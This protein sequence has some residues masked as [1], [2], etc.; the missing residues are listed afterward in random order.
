[1]F[2]I[3]ITNNKTKHKECVSLFSSKKDAKCEMQFLASEIISELSENESNIYSLI[4]DS[5]LKIFTKHKNIGWLSNQI[6][7]ICLYTL[8]II[9]FKKSNEKVTNNN[10][11]T[12]TH[13]NLCESNQ[14]TQTENNISYHSNQTPSPSLVFLDELRAKLG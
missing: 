3:L 14:S 12:Q 7:D 13:S 9:Q 1:M 8:D 5:T 2:T 10:I 6:V 4:N 11:E